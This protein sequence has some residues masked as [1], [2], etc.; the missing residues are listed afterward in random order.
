MVSGV[1][2]KLEEISKKIKEP[3]KLS[4]E[5][6]KNFTEVFEVLK[7]WLNDTLEI[8]LEK[9]RDEAYR[10]LNLLIAA[11]KKVDIDYVAG[12]ASPIAK[13]ER[14][15]P[16]EK[17]GLASP[18]AE[19]LPKEP[20]IKPDLMELIKQLPPKERGIA[21]RLDCYKNYQELESNEA[22]CPDCSL[23]KLIE[24]I[25]IIDPSI[26]P[27]EDIIREVEAARRGE[28]I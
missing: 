5:E 28:Q 4:S 8:L 1:G 9:D 12:V 3:P 6:K 17:S 14:N 19:I 23:G 7:G 2:E 21:S 11:L 26:D 16:D 20:V 18:E 15:P 22:T 13:N 27:V 24:C 10:Y 25:R